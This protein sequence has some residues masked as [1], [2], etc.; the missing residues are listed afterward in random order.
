MPTPQTDR[1]SFADEETG[2]ISYCPLCE[3]SFSAGETR[4]LGCRDEG[5]LL[6]IRCGNCSN[7]ILSLVLVSPVGVSSVGLVTD[8]RFDEVGRFKEA[9]TVT[10][11]DVIEAHRL[12]ADESLLWS[13][14]FA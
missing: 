12:L 1:R 11:D 7:A 5:Q 9:E 6:H 4:V 3:A 14:V 13:G 8:L 2:L 10:T